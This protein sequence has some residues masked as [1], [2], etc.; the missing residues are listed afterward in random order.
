MV[1][2]MKVAEKDIVNV[3]RVKQKE[4]K[5]VKH[6]RQPYPKRYRDQ[7]ERRKVDNR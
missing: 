6:A 2:H 1:A 5:K 7:R 3:D 4:D